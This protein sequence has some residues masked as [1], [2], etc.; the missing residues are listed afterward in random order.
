[1]FSKESLDKLPDR[2]PWDHAIELK[3]DSEPFRC[4]LYLLA[5]NEQ[6]E[7]D[8]FLEDNLKSGRIQPQNPP[9]H[10]QFFF[11]KKKDGS[12]RWIQD[13]RKLNDITIKNSYPLPLIS[14]IIGKLKKSKYFTKLDV[15]WGYNNVRIKK[16]DEWKAAFKTNRELLSGQY[17]LYIVAIY[18]I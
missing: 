13:Y 8:V 17:I 10:L 15:R 7:L 2:K 11:V 6:K 4:K 12:L 1:V 16:G 9:W 3:P 18:L 5:P 14:D